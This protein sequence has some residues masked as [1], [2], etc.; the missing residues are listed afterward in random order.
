MMSNLHHGGATP[1]DPLHP[2]PAFITTI[3]WTPQPEVYTSMTFADDADAAMQVALESFRAAHPGAVM[4]GVGVE[5]GEMV[6]RE[7]CTNAT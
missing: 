2:Q 7:E 3:R 5:V 6:M 1:P 4:V